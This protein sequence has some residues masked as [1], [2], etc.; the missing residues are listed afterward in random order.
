VMR[1]SSNARYDHTKGDTRADGAAC[2]ADGS[3]FAVRAQPAGIFEVGAKRGAT[4]LF[5]KR[6]DVLLRRAADFAEAVPDFSSIRGLTAQIESWG[7]SGPVSGYRAYEE[8]VDAV[9]IQE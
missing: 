1:V 4:A 3:G 7:G 6:A 5:L 9:E 2:A 8:I